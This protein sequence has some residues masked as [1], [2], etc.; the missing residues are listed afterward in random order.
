[1][2]KNSKTASTFSTRDIYRWL[3]KNKFFGLDIIP[4]ESEF[5]AIIRAVHTE[6]K[7]S[8]YDGNEITLPAR[9]GKLEIRKR[10]PVVEIRCNKVY[11]N[12]PVDWKITRELWKEDINSRN[13]KT[14]I[15]KDESAV[16]R[17][18]YNKRTACYE[19][20][21]FYRFTPMRSFK[22]E[23]KDKINNNEINICLL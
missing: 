14:L 23:L 2:K 10:E 17:I 22:L 5:I 13:N 16:Y 21:T 20:K 18:I 9:M 19:N 11:T 15:R 1:M 12:K 7:N 6:I 4:S 8:L 3:K